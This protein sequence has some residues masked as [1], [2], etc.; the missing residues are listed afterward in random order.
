MS[1]QFD[2][3]KIVP[4]KLVD[5]M[6]TSYINYAMSVIVDRAL[7]DVRDGLKPV[8]RRIIY[9][10]GEMGL[11]P[12]RPHRKS[13]G[14]VGE[15][16]G[17][18]HPHGDSAIYDAMVRMAQDFSY[19]YPLVDGHG[20]FGS[21]D[22]DPPA[23]M[24]YTEARLSRL[25]ME[26]LRDIDKGT[27]D[28]IPNYDETVEQPVVLPSRFPNLLVN[29]A[30]GIAVGMATNIPPH[31]LGEVIDGIIM[32]ID[33][34]DVTIK[35]L[36]QVIKGPDFPTGGLI[37]GRE[38]IKEAYET[39]KG[40][41]VVRGKCEIEE[42]KGGKQ[43]I[44]VTELPYN[45]N[46]RRL[47][48]KIADLVRDRKIDGITDLR[49]ESDRTGMRIVI[50]LRRD[51]NARVILNQLY[52][53]TQLQDTFGV[54]MLALVD[55][56]PK[57]LNLKELLHYYVEHQKE[58]IIRRCKF[59][60]EKAENDAHIRAGLL[61]ALDHIDEVISIIRKSPSDQAAKET[62]MSRFELTERQA[63]AILDMQLRRLTGLEREKIEE[64]YAQLLQTIQRLKTI[65]GDINL[66]YNIIKEELLE[67][68][69]RFDDTRRTR[70]VRDDS[71]LDV[72]DLIPEEDLVVTLTHHG[73]I[74]RLPVD[75]YR[76]Q[77]R[78]GRGITAISSKSE[79][80]VEQL[81]ITSTHNFVLFFTNKG[82]VH[83]LKGHEIP[84]A[85]RNARGVSVVNLIHLDPGERIEATIP[86]S[87]YSE[88]QYLIMA[89]KQGIVK[90]TALIEYDSPR[91]G[92][93][94]ILLAEDDEVVSVRLTDG[95]Q[96][97]IMVTSEGQ[98]IRFSEKHVRP[99]GR[100]ARGVKGITLE[101]DDYVVSM[102]V[103]AN[104]QDLLVV[105]ENGF[106]K[107]TS[108]EDYRVTNRGGKGIKTL[109]KTAKTGRIIGAKMVD[110]N[111]EI[112]LIS[113]EGIMIRLPVADISCMGRDT[114]GVILMKLGEDD[115]VVAAA[116]LAAKDDE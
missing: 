36:A 113:L 40:R 106:G 42:M 83:R 57:V 65:L 23:A 107:R 95:N 31:N 7:P 80:F 43:Q 76:S 110:E 103:A 6:K 1:L 28:F 3:G 79:D 32:L 48:E 74:K 109:K 14:I 89:T 27:V 51:A 39:G 69:E 66:I 41:I 47:I 98:A 105:T 78:G 13:A 29:G 60:L 9:T 108:I 17:K 35:D 85:G 53:H 59:E 33:N 73:Y 5:E 96:E 54:I 70:I 104:G 4:I 91:S 2:E 71:S 58:V 55:N 20:N 25:A 67:I 49:D 90:K 77:R 34:P 11:R 111:N 112:M 82:R 92:L 99:M 22:D 72:E 19:R 8:Q 12:D 45:V 38:G 114:Q 84:E 101:K 56:E 52:K 26:M 30:S 102:D 88:D 100:S 46:K 116:H 50:E 115:K 68:K 63:V 24:R 37:L 75:T 10:M 18:L 61:I 93:I 81:F 94:G 44:I 15:V 16:M 86:I 21:V 97:I 62:L 87:E 64:E